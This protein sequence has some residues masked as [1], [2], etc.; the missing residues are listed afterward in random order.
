MK[1]FVCLDAEY[2]IQPEKDCVDTIIIGVRSKA[3]NANCA[4][5]INN[6]YLS[7][8]TCESI[9]S[10]L[11]AM[12]SNMVYQANNNLLVGEENGR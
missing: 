2:F 3:L 1:N 10:D 12:E 11:R 6:E 5:R 4:L 8:S 7:K 9:M